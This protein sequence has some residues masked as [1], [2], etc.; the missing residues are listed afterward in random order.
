MLCFFGSSSLVPKL[1]HSRIQCIVPNNWV[2]L[3]WTTKCY[4]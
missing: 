4:V 1:T 2:K 3:I